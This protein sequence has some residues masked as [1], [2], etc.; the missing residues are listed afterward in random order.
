MINVGIIGLGGM[1]R[2]HFS[3]YKNNPDANIVA[4]CDV[5]NAKLSGGGDVELNIGA[6]GALDL[7]GIQTYND[8]REL[9]SNPNVQLVDICLPTHLHAEF[10]I[11]ALRAGKHVLCEKPIALT[12][13]EAAQMQAAQ[14]ESGQQLMIG[15]CLRYWP[16]YLKAHEIIQSGEYGKPLYARFH[17]SSA[18]PTWSWDKWLQDGARSGG[19]VLDMHIHDADTALWWFGTPES[20]HADGHI[21]DGLPMSVDATW[22]YESG[23]VAYLH[24]SWDD[25]GGPFRM[26]YKVVLEKATIAWDS[27]VSEAV[28]LYASGETREIETPGTMAYQAEINDF[29]SCVKE[30]R[31]MTRVTPEGSRQSLECVLEELRQIQEK[32]GT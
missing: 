8:A 16:Q 21:I 11:A 12:A 1:G 20:I 31:P 22:R 14:Q 24:G 3:C 4:I 18:T 28:Q 29:V 17:R 25:N 15:H 2:T 9:L 27:S 5:D 13:E 32:S 26:A 6:T 19:A 7:S 30:G 10:A 23:L